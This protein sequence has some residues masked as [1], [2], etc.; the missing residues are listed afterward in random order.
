MEM[1][2]LI[3][4]AIIAVLTTEVAELKT[5]TFE[6]VRIAIDDYLDH[7]VPAVQIW[8]MSQDIEHQRGYQQVSWN[9]ALEIVMKS[10]STGEVKQKDLW[11]IRRKIELALWNNPNLLI[12]GMIHLV[13]RRNVTD[14][15]LLEPYFVARMEF[16]ALFRRPLTGSC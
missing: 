12:P 11:A 14:L 16:E 1:E 7:E 9:L 4:N 13:Y 2:E 5:L 6:K 15:H 3:A 8:D 10:L